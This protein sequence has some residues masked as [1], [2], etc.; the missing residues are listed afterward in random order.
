MVVDWFHILYLFD[1]V[2]ICVHKMPDGGHVV[3]YDCICIHLACVRFPSVSYGVSC[4]VLMSGSCIWFI[5]RFLW[6]PMVACG[7]LLF[8]LTSYDFLWCHRVSSC[9]FLYLFVSYSGL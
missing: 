9:G 2:F 8:L 1:C 5:G 6:S 7:V 4:G 3:A